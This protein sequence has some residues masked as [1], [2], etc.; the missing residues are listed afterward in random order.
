MKP[1]TMATRRVLEG[2]FGEALPLVQVVFNDTMAFGVILA[3][4][5]VPRRVVPILFPPGE[6]VT[7][8]LHLVDAYAALLGIVGLLSWITLDMYD[9]FGRRLRR[10]RHA[11]EGS[12]HGR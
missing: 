4:I 3:C 9:V 6:F 8:L 10:P 7:D 2:L 12:G 5:Y 11:R 1:R